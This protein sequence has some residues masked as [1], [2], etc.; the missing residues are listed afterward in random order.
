MYL[1]GRAKNKTEILVADQGKGLDGSPRR[2]EERNCFWWEVNGGIPLTAE[3]P[4]N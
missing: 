4:R 3:R 2:N 1:C